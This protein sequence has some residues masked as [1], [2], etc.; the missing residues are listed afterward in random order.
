MQTNPVSRENSKRSNEGGT[1]MEKTL[2]DNLRMTGRITRTSFARGLWWGLIGGLTGTAIM[3]LVLMGALSALGSPALI[4]FSIVGE[5]VARFFSIQTV[6]MGRALQLGIKT[7]Y[8]VG[9]LVGVIFG[10]VVGR[11]GALRVNTLKKSILLAIVYVEILSQ[12]ILA[13]TPILLRMT[14]SATLQWYGGSF[15]MH[16]LLA[17]VLGAVVGLGL[18]QESAPRSKSN[19]FIQTN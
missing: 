9:P 3:D 1:D 18:R 6:G 19:N 11:V 16:L 2:Q 12:P 7:H 14:A 13:T 15:V 17:V 8:L 4:C 10:A 5:T